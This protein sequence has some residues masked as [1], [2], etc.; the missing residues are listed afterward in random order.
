MAGG[1]IASLFALA[2]RPHPGCG[3]FSKRM[4]QEIF[5]TR[6][7]TDHHGQ[8]AYLSAAELQDL[9]AFLLSLEGDK[10]WVQDLERVE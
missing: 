5:I 8:T 3:E 9:V 2:F 7:P 10:S 4:E 6:N 1:Y